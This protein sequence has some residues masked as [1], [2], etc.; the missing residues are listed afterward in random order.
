MAHKKGAGACRNGRDSNPQ[1]LG[2]KAYDGELITSG[3]V[4]VRQRGAKFRPHVNTGK[5]K[6]DTIFATSD[7]FVWF[8]GRNVSVRAEPKSPRTAPTA[9]AAARA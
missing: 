2:V 5:G 1:S 3:S 6:D 7:G 8:E 9:L 4:I